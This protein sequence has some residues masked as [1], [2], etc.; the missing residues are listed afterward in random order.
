LQAQREAA[1]N[2][3]HPVNDGLKAFFEERKR[4]LESIKNDNKQ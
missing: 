4:A 1:K 2:P 3:N